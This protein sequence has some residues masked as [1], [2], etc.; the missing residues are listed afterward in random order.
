[1]SLKELKVGVALGED[2]RR[3]FKQDVTNADSLAAEMAA[4]ANTEGGTIFL[5]VADDGTLLG[6]DKADVARL[7]Q[8]ISN[9]ASQNVR[10][11]LTVQSA[12]VAVGKGRVVIVLTVPK[13][14][15]KPYFDRN[16]VIWLKSGAD[17]R[18]MNSKEELRRLFQFSDQ[19]HAD[20]LPTR[21]GIELPR[22]FRDPSVRF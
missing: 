11:P 14:L 16:G 5:G 18:R 3:L 21:A 17:K 15:D 2:R 6:L 9:A 1:M 10:S 12:N 4:F 19:F 22:H 7:N 20:Q 8:L 13:G